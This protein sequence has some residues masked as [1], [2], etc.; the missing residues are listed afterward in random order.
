[1]RRAQ[2]AFDNPALE[3]AIA[4]ANTLKLPVLVFFG[5]LARKPDATLRAYHS[6]LEGLIDTAARLKRRKIGFAMRMCDGSH[7]T[8]EFERFCE[9]VRPALVVEDENPLRRALSNSSRPTWRVDADVIVPSR[10]LLKEQFAARTIRPRIHKLLDQFTKPVG[11]REVHVA[12]KSPIAGTIAPSLDLVKTI[13]LDQRV[14]IASDFRGGTTAGLAA[15]R[16]FIRQR[17]DDYDGARNHPEIDGT[18]KLSP[19]LHFGQL[20]PHTIALAVAKSGSSKES[21]D[22]FLEQLIVRRELAINFVRFNRHY[23]YLRSCE[24]WA[25]RTLSEHS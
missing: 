7:S 13:S 21:V 10:L 22:A 3:T 16:A 14:G 11:N 18:S 20:G 15:M 9:Q 5:L 8:A 19:Y 12:W 2:R 6:M 17:L 23:R 4:A 1:M 24:P 25:M